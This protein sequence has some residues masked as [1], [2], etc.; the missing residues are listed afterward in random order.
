LDSFPT[1][2]HGKID[3][4]ELIECLKRHESKQKDNERGDLRE[5]IC[6]TILDILPYSNYD[7]NE[8]LANFDK[9][10]FVSMGGTS[11]HAV[12]KAYC[13]N[14]LDNNVVG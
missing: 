6:K 8:L 14:F 13:I 9:S 1:S 7:L 5:W 10:F 3:N 11:M 4:L 2:E 12:R